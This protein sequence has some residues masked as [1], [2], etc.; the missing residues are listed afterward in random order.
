MAMNR[1]EELK[2]MYKE[3]KPQA[4][5][6]QIK[7]TVNGKVLV[8]STLNLK[9]LN[10]KRMELQL[11]TMMN[12]ALQHEWKEYG[13]QSFE[14]EVLE[15]LEKKKTGFFDAKDALLKLEE[16]WLERLQPYGERGYNREK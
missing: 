13:E 6:Y 14:I 15:V 1:R 7:N 4:G 8:G 16:K 12:K 2:Q 9:S 5:V 11:G 3:V 10:G